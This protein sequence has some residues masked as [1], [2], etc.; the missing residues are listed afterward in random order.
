M[1]KEKHQIDPHE[2]MAD[3][4]SLNDPISGSYILERPIKTSALRIVLLLTSLVFIT[5][6]F[7][8]FELQIVSGEEY[9][10]RSENNRLRHSLI[11]ADR[12]VIYDRNHTELAWN[13]KP[14]DGNEHAE[15]Q[16]IERNGFGHILGYAKPPAKDNKGFFYRTYYEGVAGAEAIFDEELR[17]ENGTKIIETNV[18]NE[19]MSENLIQNP[20]HGEEI[21]LSIDADI[22]AKLYEVIKNATEVY[23]FRGGASVI[24]DIYTGELIALTSFPE[25]DPN[26]LFKG[27]D[28]ET[29]QKYQTDSRQ[30]YLNRALAGAFTPGSIVKPFMAEAALN[31]NLISPYKKLYSSGSLVV[32]NQYN[33]NEVFRFTDWAAH[34]SIDMRDAIAVSSNHY[35]Y[36]IGGGYN[37]QEGLGIS[38]INRYMRMFG[39]GEK[40]GIKLGSESAGIVPSPEWKAET[41]PDDPHWYLGNTYHTSI[42]QYGF[43]VT[44]I[45][46]VRATASIANGGTLLTPRI[47]TSIPLEK[48]KLDLSASDLKIIRE[49]MKMG[50]E[51]GIARS[52][53]FSNFTL[54]AKTGTAE[55]G[56]T[57]G[58]INSWV[59]GFFPYDNPRYAFA[60]LLD[61]V[62]SKNSYGAA[63]NMR[64]FFQWLITEKPEYAFPDKLQ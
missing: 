28:R 50:V 20:K 47:S 58:Y 8:L 21:H 33:P 4:S 45:Q 23:G 38:R 41:F 64:A 29:I 42:G 36:V 15:R 52:L 22:N 12:G 34:G 44:P 27:K 16:Y 6:S 14:I 56:T 54:G 10:E 17:G 31:E 46:A 11:L 9:R 1:Y 59:I 43:L 32:K 39:F 63:P 18:L 62:S 24:M 49:G 55:V 53:K 2:V 7:K 48:E 35:F 5:F 57:K 3:S 51:T 40:T 30:P 37:D 25:T 19:V 61:H 26:V 60:T 13:E